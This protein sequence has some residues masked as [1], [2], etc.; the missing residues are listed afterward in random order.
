ML[1]DP[2]LGAPRHGAAGVAA[3]SDP[4]H[5]AAPHLPSERVGDDL[6]GAA[7]DGEA[8][9]LDPL[10]ELADARTPMA[11]GASLVA[12]ADVRR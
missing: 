9:G 11:A 7:R 10:D 3:A 4:D 5:A 12:Q 2:P 6:A 1:A 8:P